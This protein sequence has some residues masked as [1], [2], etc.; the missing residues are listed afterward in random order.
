[1]ASHQ[2]V[3]KKDYKTTIR[4]PQ[5]LVHIK[6]KITLRQY[7]YWLLFLR[8]YREAYEAGIAPTDNG[9]HRIRK[10]AFEEALGYELVQS[11]LKDD[12]EAIR[13]EPIIYNF[14]NKDKQPVKRGSGFLSEW[15][16][17]AN[18]I[19]FKLPGFL[20]DSI[21]SLDLRYA[22]FQKINWSVFSSFTGKYEAILYKLCRD[23]MGA[24]LTPVMSLTQ[25]RDYMGL[26]E[27]EYAEFK[28]LSKFLIS[29][30]I[31]KINESGASDITIKAIFVREARKV[32]TV[33]FEVTKKAQ[34]LM[35]FGDDL[36]FRATLVSIP[37]AQ[38]K[39]YLEAKDRES[40]ALSIERANEYIAN[41][42]KTEKIQNI[43]AVYRTAILEDWG[44]D[45]KSKKER[46]EQVQA[47]QEKAKAEAKA[48][49]EDAKVGQLK[50]DFTLEMTLNAV[51]TLTTDERH[52]YV[53]IYIIEVGGDKASS[54]IPETTEFKDSVQ[55]LNF[56]LWLKK[57]VAPDFDQVAF[58]NWL[59]TR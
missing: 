48:L 7:K 22:I 11:E 52:N 16:V 59:K 54:Y 17:S 24:G 12:L 49:Q 37:L 41:K 29:A 53:K 3:D 21:Q 13:R 14:L 5:E 31:K 9:F 18:W 39:I 4:T 47:S 10:S 25:Y 1:M 38:Q 44:H 55:R 34:T 45:L 33:Q 58:E 43:G 8:F 42:E 19:G 35:D 15:E 51:K 27:K 40:I 20:E 28:D 50:A 30:P 26:N 46:D 32:A 23:Y 56:T 6:H 57:K 36:A 2:V